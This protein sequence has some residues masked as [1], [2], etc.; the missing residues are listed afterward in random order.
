MCNAF[1]I[2]TNPNIHVPLLS[3]MMC[4]TCEVLQMLKN[5]DHFVAATPGNFAVYLWGANS[6][7]G[8]LI[9]STPDTAAPSLTLYQVRSSGVHCVFAADLRPKLRLPT[10][11]RRAA[12]SIAT[13][14]VEVLTS[15]SAGGSRHPHASAV[16]HSSCLCGHCS[17]FCRFHLPSP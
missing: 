4:G 2:P 15:L 11:S 17:M 12:V 3:R 16:A 5:L 1:L 9:G 7:A 8:T 14:S 6:T 13:P 10:A